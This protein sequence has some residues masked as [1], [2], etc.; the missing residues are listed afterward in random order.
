MMAAGHDTLQNAAPP[1]SCQK[2]DGQ[3]FW[4]V[5]SALR[6][7]H[8]VSECDFLRH[9]CGSS[10]LRPW[11]YSE[12]EVTCFSPLRLAACLA[13]RFARF[14]LAFSWRCISFS[15]D[16]KLAPIYPSAHCM[17][18]VASGLSSS[19]CLIWDYA[20]HSV[21]MTPESTNALYA[22]TALAS[23][24][25]LRLPSCSAESASWSGIAT[26]KRSNNIFKDSLSSARLRFHSVAASNFARDWPL[27]SFFILSLASR[28]SAC[29]SDGC[30]RF[31]LRIN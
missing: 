6:N 19:A 3:R 26:G 12:D 7:V 24:D 20:N 14:C 8:E 4:G 22:L 31:L 18:L 11:F 25:S 23:A 17:V 27:A 5:A 15:F 9:C 13:S 29:S 2:Q 1:R 21:G 16:W 30:L 28:L 10:T